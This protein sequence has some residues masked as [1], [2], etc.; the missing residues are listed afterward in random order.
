MRC[1]THAHRVIA[2]ATAMLMIADASVADS[3][4]L[5]AGNQVVKNCRIQAISHGRVYF[6]DDHGAVQDRAVGEIKALSF[7]VLP[8]LDAAEAALAERNFEGALPNLLNAAAAAQTNPQKLWMH[9][10]LAKV[11]NSLG[12]YVQSA[13]HAAAAYALDDHSSWKML[14]PTCKPDEP[15]FP[16]V[17]EAMGNLRDA[18]SKVKSTELIQSIDKM[19]GVVL[20]I[21]SRLSA[22]YT[23]P[24]IEPGSTIS[25]ISIDKIKT[26]APASRPTSGQPPAAPQPA[27]P[28]GNKQE[29]KP[30]PAD[31]ID[32]L[33]AA[34]RFSE[35]VTMCEQIAK[36][37]GERD[38]S[39]FLFQYGSAL[40]GAKKNDEASVM[41]ARCAVLFPATDSGPPSLLELALI[42]HDHFHKPPTAKRLAQDAAERAKQRG[43]TPTADRAAALLKEL[44]ASPSQ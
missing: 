35:A 5:N 34:K 29:S 22:A 11:H 27:A 23:G 24:A 7:E 44:V 13:G 33:L 6:Q 40:R 1:V 4:T 41:F 19:I 36:S 20:P 8:Q 12:Q 2:A 26:E 14:E 32:N 38:L 16:A 9:A 3:V 17:A 43:D 39:R 21:H 42:Y 18:R 30:Q 25:G 15:K 31:D 37:P 10:R 28:S